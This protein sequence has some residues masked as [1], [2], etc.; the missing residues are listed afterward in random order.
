MSHLKLFAIV[1]ILCVSAASWGAETVRLKAV[2]SVYDDGKGAAL[3]HPE[4]VACAGN[5]LL[6]GDTE[7]NRLVKYVFEEKSAKGGTEMKAAELSAPIIVQVNSKG[8]IFALD[9][10][11]R[12][13][14]RLSA[15]GAFKDFVSADGAPSQ[16][17]IVARS[18]R[19]GPDDA[20]Y[21]LD[22]FANRVLV[23]SPDGKF[24]RE[25]DFPKDVGFLEDVAVDPRGKLLALD[26]VK[27]QVLEAQK[28]AATFVPLG[29]TLA[30][31]LSFAVSLT[32]DSRG[33]IY[34][35]DADGAAVGVLS[36]DGSF[37]GT[38]LGMGRTEGSLYYPRQMCIDAN[39]NAFIAD[40]ENMR[41]QVFSIVR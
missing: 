7:N 25:V 35:V 39:G 17:S 10:K 9:G 4:G 41:V 11:Q 12:R 22:I 2:V 20:I 23:L 34:V 14:A 32:T 40:T 1:G 3:R 37:L 26:S 5:T 8:E 38:Q 18:F 21:V 15:D 31:H 27:G 13:I 28:G 36:Q 16:T 33:T 24:Q 29:A 19:V 6:V 30:E